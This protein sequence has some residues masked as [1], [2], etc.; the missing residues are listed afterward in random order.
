MVRNISLKRSMLAEILDDV[1]KDAQTKRRA[2]L[3]VEDLVSD[4]DR[5]FG[6]KRYSAAASMYTTIIRA[7]E[8][9]DMMYLYDC[10]SCAYSKAQ[11]L[12]LALTDGKHMIK[13]NRTDSRGYI[14]TAQVEALLGNWENAMAILKHGLRRVSSDDS[15]YEALERQLVRTE[16][17]A[18]RNIIYSKGTDPILRLPQ[19]LLDIV[20]STLTYRERVKLLT[21]SRPWKKWLSSGDLLARTIDTTDSR[22]RLTRAALSA[23]FARLSA[24]PRSLALGSLDRSAA[25]FVNNELRYWTRY[26]SLESLTIKDDQISLFIKYEKFTRL[27]HLSVHHDGTLARGRFMK[28]IWACPLESLQISTAC[29]FELPTELPEQHV[30]LRALSLQ[31][32]AWMKEVVTHHIFPNLEYLQLTDWEFG[33]QLDLSAHSKLQSVVFIRTVGPSGFVRLPALETLR[34]TSEQLRMRRL[35][36]HEFALPTHNLKTVSLGTRGTGYEAGNGFNIV[37]DEIQ[38]SRSVYELRL[39]Q[40]CSFR[41]L[42]ARWTARPILEHVRIF[43][44]TDTELKDEHAQDFGTMFRHLEELEIENNSHITGSFVSTLL[45]RDDNRLRK[46]VLRDCDKVSHDVVAWAKSRGVEVK[47]LRTSAQ[48]GWKLRYE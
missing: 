3:P 35:G 36:L 10:R 32:G 23:A 48:S 45:R 28:S 29:T 41:D 5:A 12:R 42:Q 31:R 30:S 8:Y 25:A 16:E 43:C 7:N 39:H 20:V 24:S 13:L 21:V 33:W 26:K 14:R 46:V 47:L 17:S 22:A 2:G 15:N 40:V 11:Q 18:R 9:S 6:E 38:E 4:A 27:R 44:Y 1:P 19:E 37:L 34:W